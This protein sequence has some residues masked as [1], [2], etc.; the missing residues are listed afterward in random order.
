[1]KK[2][3][4]QRLIESKVKKI[5][6]QEQKKALL[7][8]KMVSIISEAKNVRR[9]KNEV[10]HRI[11]ENR[12]NLKALNESI[13][14]QEQF[15]KKLSRGFRSV[16]GGGLTPQDLEDLNSERDEEEKLKVSKREEQARRE[17][18]REIQALALRTGDK[19]DRMNVLL[20]KKFDSKT[21]RTPEVS[22]LDQL[23]AAAMDLHHQLKTV[24]SSKHAGDPEV[25][26]MKQK[27][28]EVIK[29]SLFQLSQVRDKVKQNLQKQI[30]LVNGLIA[31]T[32]TRLRDRFAEYSEELAAMS[33]PET[34]YAFSPSLRG[35]VKAAKRKPV[36]PW[37]D[38]SF[39]KEPAADVSDVVA[40]QALDAPTTPELEPAT[41]SV[42]DSS[43]RRRPGA[44]APGRVRPSAAVPEVPVS[45]EPV[46]EPAKTEPA[47][48]TAR[49]RRRK[50]KGPETVEPVV[51]PT[52][53][54]PTKKRPGA[55]R[56]R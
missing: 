5:V 7:E 16:F 48:P 51:E 31:D 15:L 2:Q 50:A 13:E 53:T 14:L 8:K 55:R 41:V 27:S 12:K 40:S 54:A 56:A 6:L 3:E 32:E 22:D 37:G 1:M 36:D 25:E 42:G 20:F 29:R 44:R 30:E 45:V 23:N 47:A 21:S 38:E 39:A 46:V 49:T 4:L 11:Q 34:D 18:D 35:L 19:I 33:T 17:K 10:K 9:K 24:S 52:P 28:I 26:K 43:P